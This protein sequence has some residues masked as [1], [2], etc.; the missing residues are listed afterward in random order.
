M[1]NQIK[2]LRREDYAEMHAK[3][4]IDLITKWVE[5]R[6]PK[7]STTTKSRII[8]QCLIEIREEK[9]MITCLN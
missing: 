9:K 6:Y 2:K 3:Q 8:T 4:A 1:K 7:L 5:E